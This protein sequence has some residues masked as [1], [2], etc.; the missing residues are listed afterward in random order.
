MDTSPNCVIPETCEDDP[1]TLGLF[2][3]LAGDIALIAISWRMRTLVQE[4][5]V[6]TEVL[7]LIAEQLGVQASQD[8]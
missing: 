6:Q 1:M 7:G 8:V 4:A 3:F 5:K 2:M